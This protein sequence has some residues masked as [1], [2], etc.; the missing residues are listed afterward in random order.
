LGGPKKERI[1]KRPIVVAA[2]T[3]TANRALLEKT[4]FAR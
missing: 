1:V 3:A 4:C 2:L